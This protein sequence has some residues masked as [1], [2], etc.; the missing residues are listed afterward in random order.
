MSRERLAEMTFATF[1]LRIPGLHP[2][3][4]MS[5]ESAL[6]AAQFFGDEPTGWLLIQGTNGCGKTHLAAAVANKVLA[7]GGEVFFAVVPDLL[8]H[9]RRSYAPGRDVTH[10]D[11]FDRAR[12]ASLLVL[13]DLGAQATSPW[14]QEKLFQLVNYR[15]VAGLPTV[16]TTDQGPAELQDAHPRIWARIADPRTATPVVIL[17]PHYRLGRPQ[18]QR[19]T[20][21]G[22][23]R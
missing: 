12:E 14:A 22:P 10:D 16:V 9:L 4:R 2:E 5:L 15:T 8:D 21:R 17:A 20:Q 1:D 6:R 11:I 3:E 13:D 23:R 19:Y 18:G 7:N